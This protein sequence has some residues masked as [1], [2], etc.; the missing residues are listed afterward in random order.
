MPILRG[1][2]RGIIPAYAGSTRRCAPCPTARG[3]SSPHTRGAQRLST[4]PTRRPRDHPRIRGEHVD[5]A[6]PVQL[7]GGIIPAYAG[8]T[9]RDAVEARMGLGSSPHTRGARPGR[10][11]PPS[12]PRDHPR[13][14]GEHGMKLTKAHARAGIIPAYAGSTVP[15][16]RTRVRR[17]D[18]PRIRGEHQMSRKPR[19]LRK[20]IIPAYAGST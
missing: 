18:H 6:G 3:G 1:R 9:G 15:A 11:P 17:W 14:R 20:R 16:H 19:N 8:S 5:R 4:N 2:G 13:I 10:R 7:V 12:P